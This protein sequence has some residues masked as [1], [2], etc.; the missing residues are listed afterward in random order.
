MTRSSMMIRAIWLISDLV[1]EIS[2]LLDLRS[3]LATLENE[4]EVSFFNRD[5][6]EQFKLQPEV[7]KF[8]SPACSMF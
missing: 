6:Y 3:P 5:A 1:R 2:Q 8:R 7:S 4:T